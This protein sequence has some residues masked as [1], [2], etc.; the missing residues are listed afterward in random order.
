MNYNGVLSFGNESFTE[1]YARPFPFQ[2]PPLIAP[3]WDDIDFFFWDGLY[4]RQTNDS[5]LLQLFY[6]YT[7]LLNNGDSKTEDSYPTHLFVA[8][9]DKAPRFGIFYFYFEIEVRH[10]CMLLTLLVPSYIYKCILDS[11]C[12][13][14]SSGTWN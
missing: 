8:T 3:F 7:L 11:T 4:Y 5:D 13:Y 14:I 2:S 6:D 9:W 12:Q 1:Y 10:S